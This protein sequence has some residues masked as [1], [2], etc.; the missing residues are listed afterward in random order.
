MPRVP[1]AGILSLLL[2]MSSRVAHA[3]SGAKEGAE[4]KQGRPCFEWLDVIRKKRKQSAEPV[5][6]SASGGSSKNMKDLND[7]IVA[8]AMDGHGP[9]RNVGL[10]G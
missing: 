4:T 3:A 10:T 5:P 8:S 1:R 7:V 9:R 6:V 2:I